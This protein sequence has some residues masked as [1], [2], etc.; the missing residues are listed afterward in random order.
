MLE[1]KREKPEKE[2]GVELNRRNK[3]PLVA[4]MKPRPLPPLPVLLATS[5]K[6]L[7]K[8]TNWARPTYARWSSSSTSGRTAKT[9]KRTLP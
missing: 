9:S 2:K 6:R 7:S 1:A 3:E 4:P 8:S 5:S